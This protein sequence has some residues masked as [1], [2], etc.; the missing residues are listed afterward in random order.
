MYIHLNLAF[1]GISSHNYGLN[2][3]A[4]TPIMLNVVI[5]F[6][7]SILL[8]LCDVESV[9][10]LNIQGFVPLTWNKI[11]KRASNI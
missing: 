9:Y 8:K 3:M 5:D 4:L 2:A 10:V 11:A 1:R 6:W 7:L